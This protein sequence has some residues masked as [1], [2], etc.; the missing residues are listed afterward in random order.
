MPV[1][2]TASVPELSLEAAERGPKRRLAAVPARLWLAVCTVAIL[3]SLV[4]ALLLFRPAST[5]PYYSAVPL[6]SE[7]G[8]QL[9]PSF[10]P[11]GDRVAF[12]WEGEKQD[13]FD[14]Y[15]KQIGG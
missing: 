13:N 9:G 7:E 3:A 10:S 12:S 5:Q 15:V 2:E 14:I 1:S 11:N 6:T 4:L 8:A